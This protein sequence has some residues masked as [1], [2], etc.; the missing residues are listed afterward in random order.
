[1]SARDDDEEHNDAMRAEPEAPPAAPEPASPQPAGRLTL[2]LDS[3]VMFDPF[4][5]YL[6]LSLVVHRAFA[7]QWSDALL[8]EWT[9]VIVREGRATP[10]Q[11][12]RQFDK[13]RADFPEAWVVPALHHE[14]DGRAL[15][16]DP[17][18]AHVAACALAAAPCV[19]LTYNRDDFD[20]PGLQARG[21]EVRKPGPWLAEVFTGAPPAVRRDWLAGLNAHR[22]SMTRPPYDLP[23]YLAMAASRQ[24]AAFARAVQ[25][26]SEAEAAATQATLPGKS[27]LP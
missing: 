17:G 8:G 4:R 22:E 5:R 27:N 18:D 15:V 23:A 12:R 7:T 10:E 26:A 9:R 13:L 1:M 3:D 14:V 2:V 21:V 11:A 19:L 20:V 16:R 6:L 25:V 24:L